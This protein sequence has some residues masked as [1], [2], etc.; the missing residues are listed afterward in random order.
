MT[1]TLD[2]IP[3]GWYQVAYS[4]ELVAGDSRGIRYF[5]K[6]LVLFRTQSGEAHVLD[7]YCP[8]LG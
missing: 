1:K 3:F 4:H 2:K 8:H 7:A 6:E 5:G